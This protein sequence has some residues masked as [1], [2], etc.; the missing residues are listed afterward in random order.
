MAVKKKLKYRRILL[1]LSGEVLANRETGECIDPAKLA[2][3]AERVK[4]IHALGCQ[5]GIVL[6]EP[7]SAGLSPFSLEARDAP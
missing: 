5:V 7:L 3:M 4:K 2:F 1:K 6:G